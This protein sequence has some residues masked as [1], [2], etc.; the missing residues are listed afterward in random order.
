MT[1]L[2]IVIPS[3]ESTIQTLSGHLSTFNA[4][5]IPKPTPTHN[6]NKIATEP[7]LAEFG[8]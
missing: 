3:V 8:N 4:A 6:E 2:G 5:I 1:K 7:T